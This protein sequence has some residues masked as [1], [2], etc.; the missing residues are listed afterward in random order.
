MPTLEYH[1]LAELPTLRAG[2]FANLKIDTRPSGGK[3][4][5][6]VSRCTCKDGEREPV[7]VEVKDDTGNWRNLLDDVEDGRR[8]DVKLDAGRYA[9]FLVVVFRRGVKS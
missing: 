7:T 3:M 6:W 2:H 4:C 9:G 1:E 5:V 8:L